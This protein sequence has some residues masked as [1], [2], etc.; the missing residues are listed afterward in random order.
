[1]RYKDIMRL[2]D[3][4]IH[5]G[6]R[7]EWTDPAK[8]VW[9]DTG[10]YVPRI[11][12]KKERQ[13]SQEYGDAIKKEGVFGG[14]LIPEYSPLTAGVMP[15]ERAKEIHSLHPELIPIANINPNYNLPSSTV[16]PEF[17]YSLQAG[18]KASDIMD[19]FEDQLKAGARGL[20]IHPI[21]G[22]FYAND[23]RLYPLY[24][25]CEQEGLPVMFH[26]GTSLFKGVKMRYADPYTFDDVISDFPNLK[27]VLCHGGRGFW[28]NIAEFLVKSFQNVYIDISGLP[29]KKPP[30]LLALNEA[31]QPQIPFRHGLSRCTGDTKELRRSERPHKR[32]PG[33]GKHRLQQCL[34]LVRLLEGRHLRDKR[35]E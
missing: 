23:P 20:K 2:I 12:D 8:K 27:I 32:Y 15:F 1:M 21:H 24:D 14:I 28:Y 33:H 16:Q 10:P 13:L 3:V 29:P 7:F 18:K 31:V 34:R 35:R 4:H 11:F 6:H 26:A 22:F 19:A 5:V 25:R 9:M 30:Y 17:E